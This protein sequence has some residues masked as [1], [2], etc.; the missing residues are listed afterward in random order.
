MAYT[1]QNFKSKKALKDAIAAGECVRVFQPGPFGPDV[2][3]GQ[4]AL[5]GPH[6]PAPHTWYATAEVKDGVIIGKVR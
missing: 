6:Y 2:K 4:V 5:E 1:N 3:D